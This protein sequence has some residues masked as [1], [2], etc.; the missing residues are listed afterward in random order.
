MRSDFYPVADLH[1]H[2]L[3]SFHAYST[4]TEN[5]TEAA[6]MGLLAMACTDHGLGVPE[7]GYPWHFSNMHVIPP[8]IAGVRVFHGMEVNIMH[9][10][11]SV[12]MS[13]KQMQEMDLVIGSMHGGIMEDG[14]LDQITTAWLAVAKNPDIDIIGHCGTPRF[15]FDYERVVPVFGEYGKVVEINEGTFRVRG[16]SYENCLRIAN[17][18]KQ[19][20]VRI[21]VNSDSHFHEHIG[22][23]DHAIALL[24][25]ADFPDELIINGSRENFDAFLKEKNLQW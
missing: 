17:L 2:T 9:L 5:A 1:T 13:P 20:G 22:R 15:A 12:D 11:G 24:R 10:D 18:C 21:A 6:R 16:D 4:I 25:E 19:H 14:T 8:T 7:P 23:Y 3:Y